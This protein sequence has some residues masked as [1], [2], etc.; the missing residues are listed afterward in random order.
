MLAAGTGQA[1]DGSG[2]GGS[3]SG[4]GGGSGGGRGEGGGGRGGG[5]GRA[6]PLLDRD[7]F[8]VVSSFWPEYF[9]DEVGWCGRRSILCARARWVGVE[10]DTVGIDI[11]SVDRVGIDSV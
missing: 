4:G 8:R 3:S 5:N 10:I 11:V 2:S 6:G 9:P 1:H 7:E